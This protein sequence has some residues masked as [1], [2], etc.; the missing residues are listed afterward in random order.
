VRAEAPAFAQSESLSM[1]VLE[2]M[3]MEA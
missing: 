2:G 3:G 1:T